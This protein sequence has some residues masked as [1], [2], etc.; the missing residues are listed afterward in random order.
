MN[1]INTNARKP[2]AL[3]LWNTIDVAPSTKTTLHD[4]DY[5]H[6]LEVNINRLMRQLP[7]DQGCSKGLDM[8][9]FA[10]V[11]R[12]KSSEDA[13]CIISV[14]DN[15]ENNI[16]HVN[17][18]INN[19]EDLIMARLLNA[20][21][22]KQLPEVIFVMSLGRN[23]FTPETVKALKHWTKIVFVIPKNLRNMVHSGLTNVVPIIELADEQFYPKSIV[24]EPEIV[25]SDSD[26]DGEDQVSKIR[27]LEEPMAKLKE[28][29][30]SFGTRIVSLE[31]YERSNTVKDYAKKYGYESVW[32]YINAGE[33]ARFLL[34]RNRNTSK[35]IVTRV[36]NIDDTLKN[37]I[38]CAVTS[39]EKT[40]TSLLKEGFV[41]SENI[42]KKRVGTNLYVSNAIYG[43]I[44]K[45]KIYTESLWKRIVNHNNIKNRWKFN[46]NG[47]DA[48]GYRV[49]FDIKYQKN[50]STALIDGKKII[51]GNVN[52]P[53]R[54]SFTKK[55][56]NGFVMWCT[57]IP[58]SVA[59]YRIS[60]K[61]RYKFAEKIMKM[62]LVFLKDMTLGRITE[63]VQIGITEKLLIIDDQ[64]VYIPNY[65][66]QQCE[67]LRNK[68]CPGWTKSFFVIETVNDSI[69]WSNVT[70]LGCVSTDIH[71]DQRD[72][73]RFSFAR[74]GYDLFNSKSICV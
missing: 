1:Q 20:I 36:D 25:Y 66:T 67:D 37:M 39:F 26:S 46:S 69:S 73:S 13:R 55:T 54:N 30:L 38:K 49:L 12:Y 61:G 23:N 24:E 16:S 60:S 22:R 40:C 53:D 51:L 58:D 10:V 45:N 8:E 3:F 9:K 59:T 64:R 14:M 21:R 41:L 65:T 6:Q 42:V 48:Q 62:D 4:E 7:V 50:V 68:L 11:D 5:Q 70:K 74:Q 29:A 28:V 43:E 17:N 72:E 35:V 34:I 33:R 57:D 27:I 19:A 2:W 31:N 15:N 56:W 18:T 32:E 44:Y 52:K 47:K 63:L 71:Q